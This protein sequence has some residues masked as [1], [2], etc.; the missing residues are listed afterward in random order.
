MS[1]LS[2]ESLRITFAGAAA[3]SVDG[4]D[5]R[6]EAGQ[7]VGF[8]RGGVGLQSDLDIGIK[9]EKRSRTVDQGAG[10]CWRH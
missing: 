7:R 6:V 2:I 10:R 9:L 5:I 3:P 1:L 8:C 4:V